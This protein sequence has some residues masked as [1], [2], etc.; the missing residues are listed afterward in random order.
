MQEQRLE[1]KQLIHRINKAEKYFKTCSK[2]D[3]DKHLPLFLD[4]FNKACKLEKQLKEVMK[5]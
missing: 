1:Y 2:K 3:L 5:I 4:L